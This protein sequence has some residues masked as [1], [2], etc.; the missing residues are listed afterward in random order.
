MDAGCPC[1]I[2]DVPRFSIT[3]VL[4]PLHLLTKCLEATADGG[5]E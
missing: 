5:W 4:A 3:S 1:P 2:C